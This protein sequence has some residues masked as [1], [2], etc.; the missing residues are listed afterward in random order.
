MPSTISLVALSPPV[1]T[2]RSLSSHCK[3]EQ[4]NCPALKYLAVA[5]RFPARLLS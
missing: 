2:E 4:L 1:T 3:Q 5:V